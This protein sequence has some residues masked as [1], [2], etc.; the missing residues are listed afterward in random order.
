VKPGA[1]IGGLNALE[2]KI[3][4]PEGIVNDSTEGIG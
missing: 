2:A 1:M 4:L 3:G